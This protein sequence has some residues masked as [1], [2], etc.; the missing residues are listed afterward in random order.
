MAKKAIKIKNKL[1]KCVQRFFPIYW[2]K[3]QVCLQNKSNHRLSVYPDTYTLN[4]PEGSPIRVSFTGDLLLL[5]DMLYE[6]ADESYREMFGHIAPYWKQSDCSISVFEGPMA[7]SEVGY[8]NSN[9]YDRKSIYLN[10]P[11]A[12]GRAVK[13]AGIDLV[14]TAQNHILDK[15]VDGWMRTLDMLDEFGINHTGSYRNQQEKDSVKIITVR[16]KRIAVLSYTYGINKHS[17]DIF[18]SGDNMYLTRGL[19]DV[20]SPF[21]GQ[22]MQQV[23]E[24]FLQAKNAHPDM[25]IILPHM[26]TQ[27]LS[28]P[29]RMQR[30]WVDKFVELGA[31][32]VFACHPHHVQPLEWRK[33]EDGK[34]ALVVYCPGNFIYSYREHEG[35]ASMFVEVYIDE[36]S[37]EPIAAG[38]VPLYAHRMPNGTWTGVPMYDV[39]TQHF[40]SEFHVK[41]RV[42]KLNKMV[43]RVAL[44]HEIDT[45]HIQSI[46]YSQPK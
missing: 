26:G 17:C 46:Y 34:N 22:A 20:S 21:Y 23:E 19:V 33:R 37:C 42:A 9:L 24:D 1:H 25:I 5:S 40:P 45:Q 8:S 31:N 12:F 7:G 41:A 6:D 14:T 38:I 3:R 18:Y 13:E 29:D 36:N 2:E 10:F 11:D 44:G 35:D 32:V 39:L 27:F 28:Y 15:D 43:T 30:M 4:F 16:N